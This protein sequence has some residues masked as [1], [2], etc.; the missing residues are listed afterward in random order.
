VTV[1]RSEADVAAEPPRRPR[2]DSV[3][4]RA[5]ILQAAEEL[6]GSEGLSVPID[7]IADRAGVGVGTIYRHFPT[8]EALF[9]AIVRKHFQRI[10]DEATARGAEED[11]AEA[12]FGFLGLLVSEAGA[13]R[14]LADALAGAGID[15]KA[16][17]G[18]LKQELEAAIEHLLV[19]GQRDGS[20]K[21]D[22]SVADLMGLVSGACSPAER[23]SRDAGSPDRMVA[24]V[25]AGLRRTD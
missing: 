7:D 19:R 4:N 13:K 17:A 5:S 9:E 23:F 10:V 2:S 21:T 20:L 24:V 25:C 12:L 14:D 1:A 8:K 15:V 18:D 11:T 3:R 6:F 22:V 16:T